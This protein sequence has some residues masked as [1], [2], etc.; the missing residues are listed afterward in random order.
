MLLEPGHY[1]SLL[2]HPA[3]IVG[4][5]HTLL[6]CATGP[7]GVWAWLYSDI[8]GSDNIYDKHAEDNIYDKHA[9]DNIYDKHAE[10]QFKTKL[11]DT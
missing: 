10:D 8:C 4:P 9:E 5:V 11:S 1:F 7:L 2:Q 3:G 6:Q